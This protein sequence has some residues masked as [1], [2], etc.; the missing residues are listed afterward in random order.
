M[1]FNIFKNNYFFFKFINKCQK[2]ILRCAPTSSHV[3]EFLLDEQ[4]NP[5]KRWLC[6]F[7][8]YMT[9]RFIAKQSYYLDLYNNR[10]LILETS[11]FMIIHVLR[12]SRL[13][14]YVILIFTHCLIKMKWREQWTLIWLLRS[15]LR[16]VLYAK[17]VPITFTLTC[18]K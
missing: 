11:A 6:L 1:H 4:L 14:E 5:K 13:L 2:E 18:R 16:R 12:T 7:C 17:S 3:F 8:F 9:W 15:D 10:L